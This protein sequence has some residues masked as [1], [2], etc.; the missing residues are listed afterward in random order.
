MIPDIFLE[1]DAYLEDTDFIGEL[2]DVTPP[3]WVFKA[4]EYEANGMLTAKDI[5]NFR[6]EKLETEWTL[7]T[8]SAAAFAHLDIRPRETKLFTL[9]AVTT[10]DDGQLHAW[11]MRMEIN[12]GNFDFGTLKIGDASETKLKGTVEHLEMLRDGEELA[13]ITVGPPAVCFIKGVDML[14]D[15][16][17]ALGRN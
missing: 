14:A 6:M 15:F 1:V 8:M 4:I 2:A 13:R 9:K 16:N 12:F 11:V 7:K 3:K 17:A 10:D 5:N